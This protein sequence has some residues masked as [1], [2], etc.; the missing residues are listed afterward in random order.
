MRTR[1]AVSPPRV[2]FISDGA[3]IPCISRGTVLMGFATTE[4]RGPV[5]ATP[6]P[7]ADVARR[8]AAGWKAAGAAG[9]RSRR[10]TTSVL[11]DRAIR[12]K[13]QAAWWPPP[14]TVPDWINNWRYAPSLDQGCEARV[15]HPGL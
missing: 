8:P 1:S 2:L 11:P 7:V 4:E 15:A 6:W 5:R 9:V 3:T 14:I 10:A 13:Q 12:P